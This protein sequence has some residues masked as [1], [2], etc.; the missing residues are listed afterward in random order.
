METWPL[1]K[2]VPETVV[3]AKPVLGV[4]VI[5]GAAAWE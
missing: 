5:T 3:A 4:R 1:T 2:P